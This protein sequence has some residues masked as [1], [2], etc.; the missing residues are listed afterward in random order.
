MEDTWE[1][2][3]FPKIGVSQNGLREN[4]G[5]P[6]LKWMIWGEHPLFSET[7]MWVHDG[8]GD[9]PKTG[10]GLCRRDRVER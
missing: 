4:N 5:K 9:N 2:W 7:S 8:L 10:A 1:M 6:L 3:V